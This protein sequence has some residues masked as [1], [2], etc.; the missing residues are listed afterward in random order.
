MYAFQNKM[1]F[2]MIDVVQFKI[3]KLEL[4]AANIFNISA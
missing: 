1:R 4:Y 3:M 2:Q